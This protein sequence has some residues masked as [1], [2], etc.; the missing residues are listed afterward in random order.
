MSE[1]HAVPDDRFFPVITTIR[2]HIKLVSNSPVLKYAVSRG[3]L[4]E[5]CLYVPLFSGVEEMFRAYKDT[6]DRLSL[7]EVVPPP[8]TNTA[9]NFVPISQS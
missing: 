5:I 1:L 8:H 9:K 6:V 7:S 4:K 2:I 3:S